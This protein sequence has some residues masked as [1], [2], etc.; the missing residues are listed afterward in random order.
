MSPNG[1]IVSTAYASTIPA[2]TTVVAELNR[3]VV[4]VLD[5]EVVDWKKP[6]PPSSP[7]LWFFSAISY[8]ELADMVAAC[9]KYIPDGAQVIGYIF[10]GFTSQ[11]LKKL[12][13]RARPLTPYVRR[14]RRFDTIHHPIR[15]L[16]D[17]Q[18]KLL[19]TQIA[20]T[21]VGVDAVRYG[22]PGGMRDR[23]VTVNGYGRQ[24]MPVSRLLSDRMNS[25]ASEFYQ[26]TNHIRMGTVVD[27]DR[28]RAHF[29]Q[30]L[31][32][33]R[34]A[35]AYAPE[36]V[37]PRGRFPCS[38]VGQR[39]FES[40][41]AGCLV[42]GVRPSAPEAAEL[43]D[44]TDA[45]IELSDDPEQAYAELTALAADVDRLE[46]I[47]HTN[48]HQTLR[49]HDWRHRLPLIFGHLPELVPL[50]ERNAGELAESADAYRRGTG[51]LLAG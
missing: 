9:A 42:A 50:L 48:Y 47:S 18:A 24:S 20:Y 37:D 43:L 5:L 23:W 46:A 38:F 1:V 29:W 30:L 4:D 35:L 6:R 11:R 36:V 2:S 27:A 12:P 49:R 45:T 3:V 15:A 17:E 14:L 34:I 21:P 39:W 32:M 8:P 28:H 19:G 44:W 51:D 7:G 22:R 10:D 16:V 31:R 33:S 26:H 41:A 25:S 13:A 40:L